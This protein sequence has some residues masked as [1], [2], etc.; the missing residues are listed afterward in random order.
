MNEIDDDY[1]NQKAAIDILLEFYGYEYD[2]KK[3]K[4]ILNESKIRK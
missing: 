3:K 1:E 4:W 2:N